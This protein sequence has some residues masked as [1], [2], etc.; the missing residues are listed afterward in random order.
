MERSR[1]SCL[2]CVLMVVLMV[3]GGFSRA[4]VGDYCKDERRTL[5]TACNSVV[6]G[7]APTNLCC[8]RL[9]VTPLSC[10]CPV[11]TPALAALIDVN[12]AVKI[13]QGCGRTVP[14]HFKC[15]SITTP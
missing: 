13:I 15:G 3:M 14:R 8:Y 1:G 10:V 4:V 7:K 2:K 6:S 11:I 12:K 5:V 9:R